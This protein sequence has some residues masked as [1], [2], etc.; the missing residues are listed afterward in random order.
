LGALKSSAA[1]ADRSLVAGPLPAA[2]WRIAWPTMLQ[3]VI[4][5]LQGIIDHVMVGHYVGYTGNAA[6]GVSWQVFL[7]VI[8][9]VSSL[10]TGMSVLVARF[11][12]AGDLEKVNR[13]V[14][15]AVLTALALSFGVLAPLGY[16]LAPTLLDLIN[17]APEVQAEALP[18]LRI[19]FSFGGGMMLF[20]M[21]GAALRSA[22]DA[23]TP[24]RLGATITVLNIVLNVVLIRGLGPIPAFGT[25][26]AAMGTVIAM[27]SVG[28]YALV[29]L[30]RG[31]WVVRFPVGGSWRPDWGIIRA[32]FRFG[33]PAGAQGVAMSLAGV[34][35]LGFIGSLAEG[36]AAQAAYA[37][38]YTE[39]FSLIT[40]TSIG[41]MGAAATVA[42]QNLGAGQPER[43]TGA[44]HTAATFALVL[45]GGI[46][47]LF[48]AIPYRLL[49]IFG[50][51]DPLVVE[52]GVQLL[53]YLSL[54]GL[55]IAVA[56]TYTGGLQ[57]TGDTRSPLYISLVS[58]IGVP[59]GLCFI[60]QLLGTLEPADI[61][62]AILL[63]HITR[64]VLSVARFRQ[65]LWRSIEVGIEA[66]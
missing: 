21:L 53:R 55:F 45:A 59:I 51:T 42:G 23:R 41:L 28:V 13:T 40:W 48:F 61:W 12:G 58:Q 22:G 26:G 63:G 64:C 14:Y 54:S 20:Y 27:G 19:V 15:Q 52:L 62:R 10:S 47:L 36:A 2:V 11:A 4:G 1:A 7:V 31:V 38:V 44:V 18:Y 24:L 32:L 35:L 25:A 57:G 6:I 33:L 56:L 9:F 37:V 29:A 43:A 3:N 66:G 5:G 34:M 30:W 65:G 8:V 39:L 46:G 60:V 16:L 50:M 49:G 17:A